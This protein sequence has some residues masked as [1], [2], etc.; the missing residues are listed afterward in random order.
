MSFPLHFVVFRGG[1]WSRVKYALNLRVFHALATCLHTVVCNYRLSIRQLHSRLTSWNKSRKSAI[2]RHHDS[3]GLGYGATSACIRRAA[4]IRC[5]SD[6]FIRPRLSILV[7]PSYATSWAEPFSVG[8]KNKD[9]G[10]AT[11]HL[12][13][14]TLRVVNSGKAVAEDCIVFSQLLDTKTAIRTEYPYQLRWAHHLLDEPLKELDSI[15]QL[16]P[17]VLSHCE[18]KAT[19]IQRTSCPLN[20][21]LT[22]EDVANHAFEARLV[23]HASTPLPRA[24]DL[25]LLIASPTPNASKEKIRF[26]C[27]VKSAAEIEIVPVTWRLLIQGLTKPR[28][29]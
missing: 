23:T 19:I 6:F 1:F 17:M 28:T 2:S 27:V 3:Y 29:G 24:F 4:R 15:E 13:F 14:V 5:I 7:L 22:I 12:R 10:T 20:V 21:L 18:E 11:F 25:A 8:I 26:R 16:M 9:G